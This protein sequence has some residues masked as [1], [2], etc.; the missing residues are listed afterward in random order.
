MKQ[1]AIFDLDNTLLDVDHV[2]NPESETGFKHSDW[3][4]RAKSLQH[5]T[6]IPQ[7]HQALRVYAFCD[8]EVVILTSR[9]E[10]LRKETEQQLAHFGIEYSKLYMARETDPHY[11]NSHWKLEILKRLE[12][13]GKSIYVIYEDIDENV[14]TFR[15]AGYVVFQ[16]KQDVF[17]NRVRNVKRVVDNT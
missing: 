12:A 6:V 10:S 14:S 17:T 3:E 11:A 15:R 8:Y 5:D 9:P 4:G 1:V 2:L 7:V 16:T 13:K